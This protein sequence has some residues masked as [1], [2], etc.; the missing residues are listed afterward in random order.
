MANAAA[1]STLADPKEGGQV[2]AA[3]VVTRQLYSAVFRTLGP[4][5][6]AGETCSFNITASAPTGL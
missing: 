6:R 5:R 3:A 4:A 2:R 1:S